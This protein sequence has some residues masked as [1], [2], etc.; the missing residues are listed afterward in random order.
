MDGQKGAR[1]IDPV[2]TN[3]HSS[4]SKLRSGLG[5]AFTLYIVLRFPTTRGSAQNQDHGAAESIDVAFHIHT[6]PIRWQLHF[7]PFFFFLAP[8]P[9]GPPAGAFST[10]TDPA[11]PASSSVS[12]S[13]TTPPCVA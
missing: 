13:L 3:I 6:T 11:P 7:S 2:P 8:P 12:S 10:R 5:V 1:N 4:I 9:P